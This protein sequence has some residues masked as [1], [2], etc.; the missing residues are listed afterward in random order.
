MSARAQLVR[1]RIR[2]M[3]NT[4]VSRLL[5][6]MDLGFSLL[7]KGNDTYLQHREKV[8]IHAR[9]SRSLIEGFSVANYILAIK[10]S[11]VI[12]RLTARA[13]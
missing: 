2:R 1:S 8:S 13:S 11:Y 5:V 10:L 12:F 3:L 9:D 7:A 4:H 6:W